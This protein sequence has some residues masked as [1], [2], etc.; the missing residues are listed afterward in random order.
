MNRAR[1]LSSLA[2]LA[3]IVSSPLLASAQDDTIRLFEG[4]EPSAQGSIAVDSGTS[5]A[6]ASP[7]EVA[8]V[9]AFFAERGAT[10]PRAGVPSATLDKPTCALTLSAQPGMVGVEQVSLPLRQL[11]V[12]EGKASVA[13]VDGEAPTSVPAVILGC[14]KGACLSAPGADGEAK[15]LA[16]ATIALKPGSNAKDV[17]DLRARLDAARISCDRKDSGLVVESGGKLPEGAKTAPALPAAKAKGKAAKPATT[18]EEGP[19]AA[20]VEAEIKKA[21]QGTPTLD[22]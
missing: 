15:P 21:M 18:E 9:E 14:K 12:R 8:A 20:Q 10:P 22:F 6:D 2:S 3:M 17:A 4:A 5:N 13:L 11:A 19:D 1:T 16:T 7:D